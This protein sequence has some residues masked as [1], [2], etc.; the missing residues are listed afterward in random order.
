MKKK[1]TINASID[2]L[3]LL[4]LLGLSEG[5]KKASFEDLVIESFNSFPELFSLGSHNLPDSRKL[6]RPIRSLKSD[7]MINQGSDGKLSLTKIGEARAREISRS[8]GQKKLNI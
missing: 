6:D 4:G 2:S 7:K 1:K 8:L 3:I 5:K